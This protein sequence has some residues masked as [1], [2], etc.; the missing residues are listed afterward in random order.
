MISTPPLRSHGFSM[1]EVVMVVALLGVLASIITGS[2]TGLTES[3]REVVATQ[4]VET[5]NQALSRLA[6]AGR[7]IFT[8]PQIASARDEDLVV[9]TLQARDESIVGS[10]FVVPTYQPK[11]SSDTSTYRMRF[12][13][14]RFELLTPGQN[15]TGLKVEFDGSDTGPPRVIPPN[16]RPFGS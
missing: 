12:T 2:F 10:P 16:F 8:T 3:G 4:R 7:R 6:V 1:S 5:L 15:G 13:G 9:M 14:S 11:G